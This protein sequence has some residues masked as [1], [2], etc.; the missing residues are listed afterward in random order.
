M[1]D[2]KNNE[3]LIQ[4]QIDTAWFVGATYGDDDQ[5]DNFIEQGICNALSARNKEL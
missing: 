1:I 5:L 4:G 3:K 2:N